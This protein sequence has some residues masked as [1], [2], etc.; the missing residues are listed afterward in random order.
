[1]KKL[2]ATGLAVAAVALVLA[3]PARA[4]WGCCPPPCCVSWCEQTVTCYKP[5]WQTRDVPCTVMRPIPRE[6]VTQHNCTIMVPVWSDLR[7][8]YTVCTLVPRQVMREVVC[9][10]LVPV[11]VTDP[12]TGCSF[13]VCKPETYVKQVPC[14]V[15]DCV[16]SQRECWVKVCSYVPKPY[17]Y[18]VRS[19]VC[20]W[21]PEQVIRKECYCTMVPYRMKVMVPVVA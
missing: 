18:Q 17:S 13:T 12:C 15:H 3:A 8:E 5:V 4:G 2:V 7:Q 14:V 20:D 16:P 19:V 10:R 21:K 11:C 6:V 9:C 1:M